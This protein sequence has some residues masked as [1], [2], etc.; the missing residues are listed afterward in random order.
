M[1]QQE[2]KVP[3]VVQK[4][5]Q[6]SRKASPERL[7]QS[8]N[9]LGEFGGFSFLE[10]TIEGVANMNPERSTR[11]KI[12][13]TEAD[14]KKDRETLLRKIELW[15]DILNSSENVSDM[16]GKCEERGN[17]I[18]KLLSKNQLAAAESVKELERSYRS[19]ILFFKNT[20]A[21]KVRNI[22]IMN[23]SME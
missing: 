23:A 16:L 2:I 3:N 5:E 18:T 20:E 6:K 13:L 21:D 12:F 9:I 8:I 19:V 11:K 10:S 17:T 1:E 14:K 7:K 4:G 22:T 15:I